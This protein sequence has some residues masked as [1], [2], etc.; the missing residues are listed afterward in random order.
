MANPISPQNSNTLDTDPM[1]LA[2]GVT[3]YLKR[4][5][6]GSSITPTNSAYAA[7][8]QLVGLIG[9]ATPTFSAVAAGTAVGGTVLASNSLR[10][11]ATITNNGTAI[12]YLCFG[13]GASS[14]HFTAT[15]APLASGVASYYEVPFRYTGLITASWSAANGSAYMTE[16]AI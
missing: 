6:E 13:T 8:A 16:V 5:V 14:T 3:G 11:G 7:V 2:G 15:I 4:G 9:A 10:L 1:V 12:M